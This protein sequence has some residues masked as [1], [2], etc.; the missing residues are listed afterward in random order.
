MNGADE[1]NRLIQKRK[2]VREMTAD[3]M[4]EGIRNIFGASE[5]VSR[6]GISPS[7]LYNAFYRA[8]R[9][10]NVNVIPYHRLYEICDENYT[11]ED[12]ARLSHVP[13]RKV[14]F[15]KEFTKDLFGNYI[16]FDAQT[17][18]PG[19]LIREKKGYVIIMDGKPPVK[20]GMSTRRELKDEAFVIYEPLPEKQM[21][22]KDVLRF[23]YKGTSFKDMRSFV[24]FGMLSLAT[25]IILPFITQRFYDYILPALDEE[26]LIQSLTIVM[27][28]MLASVVFSTTSGL[29][30]YRMLSRGETRLKAA[31]IDR[32]FRMPT[33]IFYQHDSSDMTARTI[34]LPQTMTEVAGGMA[35]AIL[36]LVFALV[37]IVMMFMYDAE[38]TW[39]AIAC[40][41]VVTCI[42]LIVGFRQKKRA[43]IMKNAETQNQTFLFHMIN[44]ITA[45]RTA[46]AENMALNSYMN[47]YLK[48]MGM[49]MK[50][51]HARGFSNVLRTVTT[52]IVVLL[53]IFLAYDADLSVG[54][55]V[56]LTT[57]FGLVSTSVFAALDQM[58]L[59]FTKK[60][61]YDRAAVILKNVPEESSALLVPKPFVGRIFIDHLGFTYRDMEKPVLRDISL[62]IQPG[63]YIGVVGA[64]GCG[65]ST[66]MKLLLGFFEPTEGKIYYDSLD[67][68]CLDKKELRRRMGVV[69]QDGNLIAGTIAEN[70]SVTK[71]DATEEEIMQVLA[72]VGMAEDVNRMPMGIRTNLSEMSQTIS[73]GQRQRILIA[74]AILAGPRVLFMDEAT[75]ALDN[76]SQKQVSDALADLD[77]TRIVIAH[78]LS[79]VKECDRIIVIADGVIAQEGTYDELMSEEGYFRDMADRQML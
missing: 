6:L 78:R 39:V 1:A 79:T 63:E 65:K 3:G 75:S 21:S 9:N 57:L 17:G 38:A 25:G 37:Y 8:T 16:V 35:K 7:P 72:K 69:L 62:E 28:Y 10:M 42:L 70:V 55:Y 40:L 53:I 54:E 44:G 31:M 74:R 18:E 67:F 26:L 22:F 43:V 34:E 23:T 73:G 50:S 13:C 64:S 20:A 61:V 11:V 56:V 47:G 27:L 46:G 2:Q 4:S 58:M 33:G 52:T 45:L 14:V 77:M 30:L 60:P 71:P 48:P 49:K 68:E 59:F 41:V 5:G 66:L 12:I 24:I 19:V 36:G 32:V 51:E 76:I 15:D 29:C